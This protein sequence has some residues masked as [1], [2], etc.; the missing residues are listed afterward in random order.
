MCAHP[1][2]L[3]VLFHR[4]GKEGQHDDRQKEERHGHGQSPEYGQELD[5]QRSSLAGVGK[6]KPTTEQ[7]GW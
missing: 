1:A 6:V 4:S 2:A 7:D 3:V 5:L